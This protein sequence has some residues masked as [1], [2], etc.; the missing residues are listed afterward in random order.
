MIREINKAQRLK[1]RLPHFDHISLTSSCAAIT[2]HSATSGNSAYGQPDKTN[3][4]TVDAI[5]Y[6]DILF[7]YTVSATHDVNLDGLMRVVSELGLN[8]APFPFYFVVPY[9]VFPHFKLGSFVTTCSRVLSFQCH[10]VGHVP[11]DRG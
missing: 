11:T 1:I 6:P 2:Q 3:Y 9:A 8:S 4:P 10:L 7:Q 5:G